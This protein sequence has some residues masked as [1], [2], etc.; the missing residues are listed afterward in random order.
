MKAYVV[1]TYKMI[2]ENDRLTRDGILAA[3][4][5]LAIHETK[6]INTQYVKNLRKVFLTNGV[7]CWPFTWSQVTVHS[8]GLIVV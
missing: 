1:A 3:L 6:L 2:L 8:G 5:I 4:R 7:Y